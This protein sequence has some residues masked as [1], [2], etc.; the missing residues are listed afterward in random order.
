MK[1]SVNGRMPLKSGPTGNYI[2]KRKKVTVACKLSK[3]SDLNSIQLVYSPSGP[4]KSS[5]KIN[6]ESSANNTIF[7]IPKKVWLPFFK[8]LLR[9]YIESLLGGISNSLPNFKLCLKISVKY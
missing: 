8:P 7:T 6:L 5:L 4:A 1:D 3:D 9:H 2:F